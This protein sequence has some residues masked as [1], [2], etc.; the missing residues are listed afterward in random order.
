MVVVHMSFYIYIDDGAD[1]DEGGTSC[2][3]R[4]IF[5]CVMS[6]GGTSNNGS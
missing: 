4:L 5:M 3:N 2:T 1:Q 6:M